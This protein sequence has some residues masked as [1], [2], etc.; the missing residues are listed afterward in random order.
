M[1]IPASLNEYLYF[2]PKSPTP[3]GLKT[4]LVDGSIMPKRSSSTNGTGSIY[5]LRGEDVLFLSEACGTRT[6]IKG[7]F[8]PPSEYGKID[9]GYDISANR[10]HLLDLEILDL[11]NFWVAGGAYSGTVSEAHE[12]AYFELSSRVMTGVG[13]PNYVPSFSSLV[14][15]SS[16]DGLSQ[17]KI[18][19]LF[20]RIGKMECALVYLNYGNSENGS[21]HLETYDGRG[22]TDDPEAPHGSHF[23]GQNMI[24]SWNFPKGAIGSS[25]KIFLQVQYGISTFK[26]T[27]LVRSE[28]GY[29]LLDGG[30]YTI[31]NVQFSHS[32]SSDNLIQRTA[33]VGNINKPKPEWPD[34]GG[35]D[36]S[37]SDSSG[38]S[39][40]SGSGGEREFVEV[41]WSYLVSD[42]CGL[43]KLKHT[44]INDS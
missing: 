36:H 37:G 43:L 10:L 23:N 14:G 19:A 24:V 27:T 8:V 7:N 6:G 5:C 9:V 2:Q 40:G 11:K 18:S 32:F 33:S 28:F 35:G 44:N 4:M 39:S 26:N 29:C 1:S 42:V 15:F 12:N 31:D 34:A 20:D 22:Y 30:E 17:A 38:E 21:S 41:G 25:I 3:A 13:W 16:Q